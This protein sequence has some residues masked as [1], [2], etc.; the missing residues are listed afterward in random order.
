MKTEVYVVVLAG[1][2]DIQWH[3]LNKENWEKIDERDLAVQF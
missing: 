3:V 2:G 1:M